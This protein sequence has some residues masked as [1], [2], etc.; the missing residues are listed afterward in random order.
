ME[1]VDGTFELSSSSIMELLLALK[2][3]QTERS[4]LKSADL[5]SFMHLVV[6]FLPVEFNGNYIFE[7]PPLF[8]VKEGGACRL[9]GMDQK[10][11]RHAWTETATSNIFD[12]SK[13]LSF[14]YVKCMEHLRC[15]NP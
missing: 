2:E 6:E 4:N 11:D 10:F 5:G 12:P 9:D 1:G 13:K 14:K 15:V 8:V 3:K 7:L